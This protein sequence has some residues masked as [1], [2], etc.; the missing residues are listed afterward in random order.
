MFYPTTRLRRLRTNDTMRRLVRQA[1]LSIDDLVYPLFT[2]PGT[3]VKEPIESMSGCFHL[4]PDLIA[5]EA[6]EI[7]ALDLFSFLLCY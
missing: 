7:A 2:C 6:A 1:H 5:K 3:G 4:S